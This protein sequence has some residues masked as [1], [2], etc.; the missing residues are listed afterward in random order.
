MGGSSSQSWAAAAASCSTS[1]TRTGR[2]A[3]T[4]LFS[5]VYQL[6]SGSMEILVYASLTVGLFPS[7]ST[8]RL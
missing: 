4:H 8:L 2:A 3:P 6:F 5:F 1:K 7:D